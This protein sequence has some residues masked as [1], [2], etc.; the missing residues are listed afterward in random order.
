MFDFLTALFGGIF[1]YGE[2]SSEKAIERDYEKDK[3]ERYNLHKELSLTDDE[4]AKLIKTF[5]HGDRKI[6]LEML[7]GISD[8]LKEI[9]GENWRDNYPNG[10]S[11]YWS[12]ELRE[13]WGIAYHIL[14]SKMHKLA[15]FASFKYS[16][17]GGLGEQRGI[18]VINACKIIE[19]N[20]QEE[21][22]ELKLIFVPA[23]KPGTDPLEYHESL[24]LGSL[25]W[26]HMLPKTNKKYNPPVKRLW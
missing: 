8:E 19:R 2:V 24:W 4:N 21:Y 25:W 9:Y 18:Y 17:S 26:E 10:G 5:I 12:M 6:Q 20:M 11:D 1:Y 13:P 7:E 23:V 3:T 22:P 16:L 14:A 15:L